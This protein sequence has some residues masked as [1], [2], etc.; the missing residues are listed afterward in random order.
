MSKELL[1]EAAEAIELLREWIAAV[2]KDVELPA[3]PGVD[4]DWLDDV[5]S[6]LKSSGKAEICVGKH[7]L[8]DDIVL[9][10]TRTEADE[11]VRQYKD[12]F[13]TIKAFYDLG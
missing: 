3:M 1:K 9:F 8:T 12:G 13:A 6:R 7:I 4:G 10:K 2:P 11:W 5:Q